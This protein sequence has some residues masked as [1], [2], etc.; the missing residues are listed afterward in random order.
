ME[1]NTFSLNCD[2]HSVKVHCTNGETISVIKVYPERHSDIKIVFG[3]HRVNIS[4]NKPK[5]KCPQKQ[6]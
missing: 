3:R 6:G 1:E 4:D 5:N 2:A